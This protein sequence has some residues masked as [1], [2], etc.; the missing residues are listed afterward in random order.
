MDEEPEAS[1]GLS[2]LL[3]VILL[4]RGETQ[5]GTTFLLSPESIPSNIYSTDPTLY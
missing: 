3:R 4:L 5:I 1:A 2:N